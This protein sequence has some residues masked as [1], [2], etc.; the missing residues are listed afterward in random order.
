M[1]KTA[2]QHDI[3]FA[4]GLELDEATAAKI[5]DEMVYPI[6][7]E[8]ERLRDKLER[9]NREARLAILGEQSDGQAVAK[10]NGILLEGLS[11]V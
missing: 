9:V 4:T 5:I 1:G 8:A 7:S 6:C 11:D 10:I 2:A 3:H